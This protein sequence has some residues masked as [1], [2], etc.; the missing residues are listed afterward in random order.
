VPTRGEI[1]A[2]F[3]AIAAEFDASRTHP[4]RETLT[5]ASFL[6]LAAKVLDIGCGS[7]RNRAALAERGAIVVGIDASAGLLARAAA[8][9]GTGSLVR[10]DAVAL[11]FAGASFDAVHCV[12]A[13]HH[14]PSERDRRQSVREVARVLRPNGLA[15]FSV[16][17]HEQDRFRYGPVDVEAPWQRSDGHVVPRFYHLFRD[18]ELQGLVRDAGLTVNAAWREGDNH[19][20]IAAKK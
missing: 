9:M 19:V 6:P 12:A 2:A 14:L 13:V 18:G 7:G 15:L 20:V 11:P 4:W 16:W 10:G 17:A 8:K 3:D 5:F 1:A